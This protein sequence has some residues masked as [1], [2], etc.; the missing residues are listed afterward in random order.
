MKQSIRFV[1]G[2]D[3]SDSQSVLRLLD[4]ESGEVRTIRPVST[5]ADA[6]GPLFE[7]LESGTRV[8]VETG[9]HAGWI[10]RLA[11]SAGHETI[12]AD[13]RRLE[14]VTKNTRKC[15]NVDALLLAQLGASSVSLLHPVD[16]RSAEDQADLSV[17]RLRDA[18]VQVRTKLIN[19]VRG[20]VKTCGVRIRKCDTSDFHEVAATQRPAELA[21]AVDPLLDAI[22]ALN[23]SIAKHDETIE[24]LCAK[25]TETKRLLAVPFVGEIT[26]AT[27]ALVIGNPERFRD[28][29]DVGAYLGLVP[30]RDQSGKTDRQLGISKTGDELLR[31][32][33]VQ[34]AHLIM[35]KNAPDSDLKRHGLRISARG[36]KNAKKRAAVA[37]ARKLA[38]IL[39][40]LWKK[41]VAY[42]P[43]RS[44]AA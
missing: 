43:L 9:V 44:Q 2:I 1:L 34:C 5:R 28:P 14:A 29:R 20:T 16:V 40:V 39:L 10:A 7:R 22:K 37:L 42:E 32:L 30:K 12:V 23:E 3:V 33:L 17:V 11:R 35:R 26:A 25:R 4:T 15:D 24:K 31:R 8:V 13:A 18:V 6:M 36:G 41:D 27:F 21:P 19:A 38:V